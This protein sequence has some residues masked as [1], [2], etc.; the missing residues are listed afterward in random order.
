MPVASCCLKAKGPENLSQRDGGAPDRSLLVPR[1]EYDRFFL[2]GPRPQREVV[3]PAPLRISSIPL[4]P[5]R[6]AE[7]VGKCYTKYSVI[8]Q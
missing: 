2:C 5:L 3:L 7:I 4:A 6:L 8:C 1:E